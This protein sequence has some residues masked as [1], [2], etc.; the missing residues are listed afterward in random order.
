MGNFVGCLR[1]SL[2]FSLIDAPPAMIRNISGVNFAGNLSP[3]WESSCSSRLLFICKWCDKNILPDILP[4]LG[5]LIL[6]NVVCTKVL[7][8]KV[9]P[10]LSFIPIL[11]W[12][13]FL[14]NDSSLCQVDIKPA[15]T[16]DSGERG[17]APVRLFSSYEAFRKMS[18]FSV[19][20]KKFH[21]K[22]RCCDLI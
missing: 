7:R 22:E 3:A 16:G 13:L 19:S 12:G 11:S 5:D 4:Q 14:S 18:A 6:F 17:K 1:A 10:R 20:E 21:R 2:A 8:G 15:S 9:H